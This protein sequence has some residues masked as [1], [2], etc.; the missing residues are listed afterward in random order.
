MLLGGG[1]TICI[2]REML[3]LPYEGFF[4]KIQLPHLLVGVF[5]P[6]FWLEWLE[7]GNM[8]IGNKPAPQLEQP[9]KR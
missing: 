5:W 1:A 4:E 9:D 8:E 3:C 7:L 2:G 6:L